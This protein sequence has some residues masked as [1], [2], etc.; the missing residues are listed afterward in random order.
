MSKHQHD[1]TIVLAS[2]NPGKL[3]EIQQLFID[4]PYKII[5]QQE[6]SVPEITET[7]LT[8]IENAILKARNAAQ[9]SKLPVIADDSGLEIDILNGEPGIHSARFAGKNATSSANIAKVLQNL[10]NVPEQ[11]RKASFYCVMVYLRHSKDPAPIIAEGRWRG[12]ILEQ[13]Q[14]TKGFGYDP[15]FYIPSHK[16]SAAELPLEIKNKLSHRAQALQKL[17]QQLKQYSF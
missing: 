11:K 1:T 2:N 15:I 12:R 9:Y 3:Q 10:K 17:L 6:C 16:C 5:S 14:G 7:R 13:T 4:L 8:F